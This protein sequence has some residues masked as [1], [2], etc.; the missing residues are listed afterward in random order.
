MQPSWTLSVRNFG[1]IAAADVTLAPLTVLIGRNNTGKSYLASLIWGLL[2]PEGLLF[3]DRGSVFFQIPDDEAYAA[4]DAAIAQAIEAAKAGGA[5]AKIT[6]L[7]PFVAWVRH[8]LKT[9]KAE[10]LS[11]LFSVPDMDAGVISI[12]DCKDTIGDILV[13]AS[14]SGKITTMYPEHGYAIEFI[15]DSLWN[16]YLLISQIADALVKGSPKP[17]DISPRTLYVPAGR[18]G[19]VLTLPVVLSRLLGGSGALSLPLPV[20]SFLQVLTE[21]KIQSGEPACKDVA[22]YIETNILGGKI[23]RERTE[24]P[25]FA[26]TPSGAGSSIPLHVASSLVTELGPVTQILKNV[27]F[28]TIILEEPEAHLHLEAQAAM[29]RACARMVNAGINVVITTHSDTFLQQIN[30]LIHLHGHP[31]RAELMGEWGLSVDDL[32]DPDAARGYEFKEIDGRTNVVEMARKASGLVSVGM[33]EAIAE[34]ARQ[35]RELFDDSGDEA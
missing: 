35:T 6:D 31:R 24:T 22:Y 26:F 10:V 16:R 30:N 34:L 3:P 28:R 32:I 17:R 4:C 13:S 25:I 14:E 2:N 9:R 5:E 7:A 18:T 33:N 8:L 20:I 23:A 1:P 12:E 29:A 21:G 11:A 15:E 27:H 19:L